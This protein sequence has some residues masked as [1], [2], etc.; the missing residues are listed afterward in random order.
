MSRL[1][2]LALLTLVLG[3][4]ATAES[5]TSRSGAAVP[6]AARPLEPKVAGNYTGQWQSS[7][8]TTGELQLNLRQ[9]ANGAWDAVVTVGYDG[10]TLPT[11]MQSVTVN[12]TRI[13]TIY[14]L[15]GSSGE[16][17]VKMTGELNADQ[18]AGDFQVTAGGRTT[19]T[20]KWTLKR[21]G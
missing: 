9:G 14:R 21:T 17:T 16:S 2:L 18:L 13:E 11:T 5:T 15:G 3:G 1:P 8:G 7:E 19:S 10:R 12:Q 6:A 20:G 4:C